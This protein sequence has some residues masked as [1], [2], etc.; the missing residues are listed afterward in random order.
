VIKER[1]RAIGGELTVN[2]APGQGATLRIT[3]PQEIHG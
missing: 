1:V 2:S 3:V